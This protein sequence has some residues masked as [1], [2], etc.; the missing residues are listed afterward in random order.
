MCCKNEVTIVIPSY[1]HEQF[2]EEAISSAAKL[3]GCVK[4]LVL[5]DDC[6]KDNTYQK[7]EKAI[8][9]FSSHFRN[10]II[11][12]NATNLGISRTLNF[13]LDYVNTPY[14][15]VLASD[16]MVYPNKFVS[17]K[18]CLESFA[19]A[20]MAFGDAHIIDSNGK[21]IP[22]NTFITR[23]Y[24][25]RPELEKLGDGCVSFCY[26]LAGNFVPASSVLLRTEVVKKLGGW[27]PKIKMEDWYMWLKIASNGYRIVFTKEVVS[28][29]RMHSANTSFTR[30]RQMA[31][32]TIRI[33]NRFSRPA[34]SNG[35]PTVL[36]KQYIFAF[37]R[38]L[39][40]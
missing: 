37:K 28:C 21:V 39:T 3:E 20:G 27:D 15:M 1:N 10:A 33:L 17:L 14:L 31:L 4:D 2:V 7:A 12:S 5:I 36:L 23:L 24:R 8:E 11:M 16:D 34:L 6:S 35:C 9:K 22:D 19:D 38:L 30:S 13:A 32:D 29:Y 40:G 25:Y 18:K 26:L